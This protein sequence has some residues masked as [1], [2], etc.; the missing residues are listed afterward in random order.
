MRGYAA[1][2]GVGQRR[3]IL[4]KRLHQGGGVTPVAVRKASWPTTG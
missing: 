1:V 4:S 3:I 2:D